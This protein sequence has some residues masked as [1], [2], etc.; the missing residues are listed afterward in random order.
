MAYRAWGH[1]FVGSV[2]RVD[3]LHRDGDVDGG[4]KRK[5]LR[6]LIATFGSATE[7]IPTVE[8]VW[9]TGSLFC[10]DNLINDN[11]TPGQR[12]RYAYTLL[13]RQGLKA[14]R[15]EIHFPVRRSS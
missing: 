13:L 11:S 15:H 7:S 4:S 8:C 14:L 2:E 12:A 5:A 6:N 10:C 3:G 1:K 9:W